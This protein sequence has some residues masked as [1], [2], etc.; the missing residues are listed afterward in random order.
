[1]ITKKCCRC[2]LSKT[3][4]QFHKAR[5][6]LHGVHS[7]CKSCK[8]NYMEEY[9]RSG[10]L[11]IAKKKYVASEKGKITINNYRKS[12]KNK[13]LQKE[14]RNSPSG[15]IACVYKLAKYRAVQNKAMPKWVNG[16]ALRLIYNN[17][18]STL[19][20]DH[21]FPLQGEKVS[22]LHVPWNLQYLTREENAKKSNSFD[23]TYTNEG[24]K[25]A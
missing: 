21:I 6:G 18:P 14:Y 20:V 24:W 3:T 22:G 19:E 23:G 2:A 16:K 13:Q 4:D 9:V 11:K 1:M 15:K 7:I 25:Y 5:R 12:D 8:K 10:K 17:C